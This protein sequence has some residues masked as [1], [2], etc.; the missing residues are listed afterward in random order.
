[1]DTLVQGIKDWPRGIDIL[2]GASGHDHFPIYS[3][4]RQQFAVTVEKPRKIMEKPWKI[5]ENHG[6]TMEKHEKNMENHVKSSKPMENHH[7]ETLIITV[8]NKKITAG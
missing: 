2:H 6:T 1:M 3:L 5:T 4:V 7:I 8:N